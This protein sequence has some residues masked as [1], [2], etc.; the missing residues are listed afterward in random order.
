MFTGDFILL[1]IFFHFH[2][3][4]SI[5]NPSVT[6]VS[7]FVLDFAPLF[8]PEYRQILIKFLPLLR[9]S[10]TGMADMTDAI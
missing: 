4:P 10:P 1:Q 2:M 8:F 3:S 9:A 5:I 6:L 7:S